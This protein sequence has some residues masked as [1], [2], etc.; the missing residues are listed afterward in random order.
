MYSKNVYKS[1]LKPTKYC[2]ICFYITVSCILTLREFTLHT[3]TV[4]QTFLMFDMLVTVIT[5]LN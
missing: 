1:V 5:K 4:D 3:L 2:L